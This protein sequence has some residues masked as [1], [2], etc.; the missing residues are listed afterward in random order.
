MPPV[1]NDI[2]DLAAPGNCGKSREGPFLDRVFTGRERLLIARAARP[3]LLLWALWGAKEAAYKAVSRDDPSVCSIPRRYPVYLEEDWET[4]RDDHPAGFVITP[5][6]E[7]ALRLVATTDWVHALAAPAAQLERLCPG[8]D[9]PAASDD[10]S[11]FV[12]EKLLQAIGRRAGCGAGRLC[13]VKSPDGP[14]VPRLLFSGR[15]LAA[16]FSL[17]HD[18][19]FTAFV[20]DPVTLLSALDSTKNRICKS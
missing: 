9:C 7:M 2:V 18:G 13:V 19:R 20:F 17:S 4:R 3:D 6:G 8:V 12:R 1:G 14:G 11:A 10:P 16:E 15:P 5:L